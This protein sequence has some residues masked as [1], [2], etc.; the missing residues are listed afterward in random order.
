MF[1]YV[2]VGCC[3]RIF[4]QI[5]NNAMYWYWPC[6]G[7]CKTR[8]KLECVGIDGRFLCFHLKRAFNF[9]FSQSSSFY[10]FS[11]CFVFCVGVPSY[12]IVW[13]VQQRQPIRREFHIRCV[14]VKVDGMIGW[15]ISETKWTETTINYSVEIQT[16][17]LIDYD[18]K[19]NARNANV[20]FA[21]SRSFLQDEWPIDA[22]HCTFFFFF[23]FFLLPSTTSCRCSH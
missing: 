5:E 8:S 22:G 19:P 6:S 9:G 12:A 14:V 18:L 17:H 16:Y 3:V 13:S 21:C 11:F 2:C 1:A 15:R 7:P 4:I 20:R 10:F 23:F